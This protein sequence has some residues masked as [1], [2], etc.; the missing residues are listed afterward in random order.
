MWLSKLISLLSAIATGAWTLM[1]SL[2]DW[3]YRVEAEVYHDMHKTQ[4][5]YKLKQMSLLRH[6]ASTLQYLLR[7]SICPSQLKILPELWHTCTLCKSS[8]LFRLTIHNLGP[9]SPNG[10]QTGKSSWSFYLAKRMLN[11]ITNGW[12]PCTLVR[13]TAQL[14]ERVTSAHAYN[15]PTEN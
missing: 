7:T 13:K 10:V 9:S 5:K 3:M 8:K 6:L 15:Q 2:F 12:V 1:D 14:S 11:A 4:Q